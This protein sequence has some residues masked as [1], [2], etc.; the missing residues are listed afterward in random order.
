M[1]EGAEQ[2]NQNVRLRV[3]AAAFD[4]IAGDVAAVARRISCLP[5]VL[6]R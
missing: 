5:P 6:L 3:E 4:V 1:T 2:E